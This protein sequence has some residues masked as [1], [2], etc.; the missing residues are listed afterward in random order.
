VVC[1]FDEDGADE[2]SAYV[3]CTKVDCFWLGHDTECSCCF[4][5]LYLS[6]A[7]L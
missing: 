6:C 3:S 1:G 4:T 5:A 2:A 7:I